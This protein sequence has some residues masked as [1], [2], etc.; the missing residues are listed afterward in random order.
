MSNTNNL[1]QEFLAN[2]LHAAIYELKAGT[3]TSYAYQSGQRL[4]PKTISIAWGMPIGKVAN[5]GRG[6]RLRAGQMKAQFT[7]VEDS[8]YKQHKPFRVQTAIWPTEN[9]RSV[10]YGTIGLTGCSGHIEEDNGDLILFCTYDRKRILVAVFIGLATD[11]S[12][13]PEWLAQAVEYIKK[14]AAY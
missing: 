13:R 3:K 2:I 1:Q 11:Q 9:H 5:K 7:K 4:L 14:N 8:P 6:E 10:L 12:R